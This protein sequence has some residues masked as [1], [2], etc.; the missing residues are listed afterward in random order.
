VKKT[1]QNHIRFSTPASTQIRHRATLG[2][3]I[4]IASPVG[5][6]SIFFLA[7]GASVDLNDEQNQRTIPFKDF[8]KGYLQIDK[9]NNELVEGV[10]FPLPARHTDFNFDRV[11]KHAD[12]EIPSVSSAIQLQINNGSIQQIHLS[13]GGVAPIPLDLTNTVNY[14][15]GKEINVK[16]IREAGAIAQA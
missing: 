15:L 6:L 13:A 9:Q 1:E 2:G 8:F 12:S 3:N 7:L 14:L 11:C 5:D 16:V 10:H 4:V